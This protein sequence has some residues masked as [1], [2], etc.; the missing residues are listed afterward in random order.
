MHRHRKRSDMIFLHVVAPLQ[1]LGIFDV[2]KTGAAPDHEQLPD[3]FFDRQLVQS[4]L[5]PLVGTGCICRRGGSR[6]AFVLI[7]SGSRQS[8]RELEN[9]NEKKRSRNS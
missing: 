6:F 2:E 4:L 1:V 9:E 8:E 3:L 7:L 5:S